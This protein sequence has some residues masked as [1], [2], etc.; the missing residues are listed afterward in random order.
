MVSFSEYQIYSL[1]KTDF[2]FGLTD[3]DCIYLCSIQVVSAIVK[4]LLLENDFYAEIKI[5]YWFCLIW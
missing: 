4:V 3:E 1:D 5:V 2:F